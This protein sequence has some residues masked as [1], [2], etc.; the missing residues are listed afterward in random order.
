MSYILIVLGSINKIKG[1]VWIFT[2]VY[3]DIN[4]DNALL[5][6]KI[7]SKLSGIACIIDDKTIRIR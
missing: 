3:A 7:K 2:D 6:G 5:N 1:A 4:K